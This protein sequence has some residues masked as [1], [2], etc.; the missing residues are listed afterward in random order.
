MTDNRKYRDEDWLREQYIDQHRTMAEIAEGCGCSHSTIH[1]W[2]E[3]HGIDPRCRGYGDKDDK[4]RDGDWL[5][6]Q[7]VEQQKT[8]SE[9][10]E[11]YECSHTTILK[12][13][14]KH[15]IESRARGTGDKDGKYRDEAWLRE[16]YIGEEKSITDIGRECDVSDDTILKWLRKYDISTREPE[17][18][19]EDLAADKQLTDVDWLRGKYVEE[20]MNSY[21]IAECLSCS[22][23]S[24]RY[25][26]NEHGIE[27]RSNTKP[28]DARLADSDWLEKQY[29]DKRLRGVEIAQKCGCSRRAVYRWLDRHNIETFPHPSG[30]DHPHWSGGPVHYGA[31]WNASKKRRVRERDDHMC[32]DPRCSVTQADHLDE[33]G[34]KLHVHHLRKARDVDDA[35]KRNAKENLITLCRDCHRRWEKIA[36]AGLV[37]QLTRDTAN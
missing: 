33:Y 23:T 3:K 13:L 9:I 16:M 30:Q 22:A 32:Q 18:R 26:L 17:A 37:P 15:G 31:G 34:Q 28:A 5:R 2:I 24:V 12:W 11:E 21:E 1:D 14:K 19:P 27:M 10:A 4:Y 20:G 6:E 7:Y 8:A 35:E 29:R 36:D 25:W